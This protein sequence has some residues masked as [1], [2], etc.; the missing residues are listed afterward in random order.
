MT[1]AKAIL[2]GLSEAQKRNID[3][4]WYGP[5]GWRVPNASDPLHRIGVTSGT[6]LTGLG[7]QVR[8]LIEKP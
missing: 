6:R 2:E 4:A 1:D 7:L 8:A 3:G 5:R